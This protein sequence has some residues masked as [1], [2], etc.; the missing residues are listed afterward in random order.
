MTMWFAGE[1]Q[2]TRGK[3][4]KIL[5]ATIYHADSKRGVRGKNKRTSPAFVIIIMRPMMS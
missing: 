5:F 1:S 3:T 2:D 4:G